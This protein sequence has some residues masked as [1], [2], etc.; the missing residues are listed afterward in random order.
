MGHDS[1]RFLFRE[2]F[3]IIVCRKELSLFFLPSP[4]NT[5]TA[6]QTC[7]KQKHGGNIDPLNYL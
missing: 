6:N 2:P 5:G 1:K 3:L 7:T 4:G